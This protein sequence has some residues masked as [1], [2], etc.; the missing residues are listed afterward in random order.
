VTKLKLLILQLTI[1][2]VFTSPSYSSDNAS[3]L[4][5]GRLRREARV[6]NSSGRLQGDQDFTLLFSGTEDR[7]TTRLLTAVPW[8]HYSI[9]ERIRYLWSGQQPD[10]PHLTGTMT[11]HGILTNGHGFIGEAPCFENAILKRLRFQGRFFRIFHLVRAEQGVTLEYFPAQPS[12]LYYQAKYN[13]LL[14][15]FIIP[16]FNIYRAEQVESVWAMQGYV[17]RRFSWRHQWFYGWLDHKHDVALV[18]LQNTPHPVFTA[19]ICAQLPTLKHLVSICQYPNGH[20]LQKRS[21]EYA[22]FDKLT[23]QCVT[24][25]GSSGSSLRLRQEVSS[26]QQKTNFLRWL[27]DFVRQTGNPLRNKESFSRFLAQMDHFRKQSAIG[28]IVGIHDAGAEGFFN[29][30]VPINQDGI[31]MIDK[32]IY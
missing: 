29:T 4:K 16:D 12:A 20:L 3:E 24:L 25:P 14:D 22:D 11:E 26:L 31:T 28:E 15:P 32:R 18:K 17:H 30:F 19:P 6:P 2:L 21:T 7:A 5:D 13:S 23:H 8:Q 9:R 10:V 27:K 1:V